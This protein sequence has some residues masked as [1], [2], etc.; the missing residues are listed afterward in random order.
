MAFLNRATTALFYR[1]LCHRSWHVKLLLEFRNI[2]II[3]EFGFLGIPIP[4]SLCH[5]S[6]IQHL[7]CCVAFLGRGEFQNE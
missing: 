1:L 5:K 3:G 6:I 2:R 7:E 4:H